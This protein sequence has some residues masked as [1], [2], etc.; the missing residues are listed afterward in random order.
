MPD[1]AIYLSGGPGYDGGTPGT[2]AEGSVIAKERAV[3]LFDPRGTG[4]SDPNVNC[5]EWDKTLLETFITVLPHKTALANMSNAASDCHE[6]LL[7][8]GIVL[9]AFNTPEIARDVADIRVSLGYPEW[10]LLG[11]SYGGRLANELMRTDPTG[12]RTAILDSVYTHLRGGIWDLANSGEMAKNVFFEACSNDESCRWHFP[13][14]E[15]TFVSISEDLDANPPVVPIEVNGQPLEAQVSSVE[16]WSGI[17]QALYEENQIAL[18]PFLAVA[19]QMNS[20][21]MLSPIFSDGYGSAL[22]LGDGMSMSVECSELPYSWDLEKETEIIENPGDW[23]KKLSTSH[24]SYCSVW[25]VELVNPHFAEPVISEIPAL[26]LAGAFDPITPPSYTIETLETLE[27]GQMVTFG[28]IGHGVIFPSVNYDCS[29]QIVIDFLTNPLEKVD[30][31]C[32]DNLKI[33]FSILNL[34]LGSSPPE[35]TPTTNTQVEST[36]SDSELRSRFESTMLSVLGGDLTFAGCA[37]SILGQEKALSLVTTTPTDQDLLLLEDCITDFENSQAAD[38]WG[39]EIDTPVEFLYASDVPSRVRELL[40]EAITAATEEWGNFG[41]T[42]YWVA[43]IDVT[44]AEELADQYC[45]RWDDRGKMDKSECLKNEHT[46]KFLPEQAAAV[47]TAIETGRATSNAGRNGNRNWGVHMFSSSY[48]LGFAGLLGVP[49]AD[50]Q[51]VALHEYFHAVQHAYIFTKNRDTRDELM[52][53]MWWSEGS[54]EYMAQVTS[55]SLRESGAITASDWNPL[56]DRF[57]WK[58]EDVQEWLQ[59]NPGQTANTIEYGPEQN[60]G[61][62]YGTWAIAYLVDKFGEGLVLGNFYPKLNDLGWEGAFV[63]TYGMSSSD[64]IYEF[65]QFVSLPISEQLLIL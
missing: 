27:N 65:N 18:L 63:D 23:A 7:S 47:A 12:T 22:G 29:D 44:A 36:I 42:E 40:E 62:S 35:T 20:T 1:P 21:D 19:L 25:P 33:D 41:P 57:Q 9:E 32:A 54:A 13:D 48:P 24:R 26:G 11:I 55:Q 15:Q 60:V 56:R 53:P 39:Q 50:D 61:Y 43:G 16:G 4:L 49:F 17:Y 6:R 5:P 10:N 2:W 28:N 46:A 64:F 45:T 58:M 51:K 3:I 8:E 30:A 52:G 38:T 59:S 31:S 34:L 37:A 14:I